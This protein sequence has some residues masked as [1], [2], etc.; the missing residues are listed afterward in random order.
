MGFDLIVKGSTSTL[1]EP[2]M[3]EIAGEPAP[4]T[5]TVLAAKF[6]LAL[7]LRQSTDSNAG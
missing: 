2:P 3:N 6:D 5:M 1:V 7:M 4:R